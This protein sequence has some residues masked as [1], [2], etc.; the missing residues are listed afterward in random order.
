MTKT[1]G[2]SFSSN[3]RMTFL[4]SYLFVKE[5]GTRCRTTKK[6]SL[7]SRLYT[8]VRLYIGVSALEDHVAIH[9]LRNVHTGHTSTFGHSKGQ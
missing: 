6:V 2:M 4:K 1:R 8:A 5:E 3:T 7:E 9:S